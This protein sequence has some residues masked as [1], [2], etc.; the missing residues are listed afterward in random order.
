[1]EKSS[2]TKKR[3]S[4]LLELFLVHFNPNDGG[5]SPSA[6]AMSQGQKKYQ[7]K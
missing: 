7:M 4:R 1:L 2:D 6:R 3:G 5:I